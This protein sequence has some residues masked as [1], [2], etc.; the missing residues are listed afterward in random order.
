MVA[1]TS[2]VR[3]EP[4]WTVSSFEIY[5]ESVSGGERARW[6]KMPASEKVGYKGSDRLVVKDESQYYKK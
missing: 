1:C 5:L 6:I 2:L 4:R 3:L